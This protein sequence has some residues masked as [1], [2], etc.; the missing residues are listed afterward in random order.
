M[1]AHFAAALQQ[2]HRT[3]AH[4]AAQN[5]ALCLSVL[6]RVSS[7][8]LRFN[9]RVELVLCELSQGHQRFEKLDSRRATLNRDE[10]TQGLGMRRPKAKRLLQ[11]RFGALEIRTLLFT[12]FRHAN[13]QL[14]L[15]RR[16]EPRHVESG[17]GRCSK[18]R[19]PS[20]LS[21]LGFDQRQKV[22]WNL[23]GALCDRQKHLERERELSVLRPDAHHRARVLRVLRHG[24][25]RRHIGCERPLSVAQE[26]FG[27]VAFE[28]RELRRP[29]ALVIE[30]AVRCVERVGE[31]LKTRQLFRKTPQVCVALARLWVFL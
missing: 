17:F 18:R 23:V 19:I 16:V 5:P 31:G 13:Q 2:E 11:E 27:K 4:E 10:P 15:D 29:W 26:A 24:A 22:L 12:P 21:S 3:A 1:P 9:Q 8:H 20:R 7:Q 28:T 25:K 6:Q 14:A 30:L